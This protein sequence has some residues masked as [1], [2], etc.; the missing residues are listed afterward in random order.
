MSHPLPS[1]C[2]PRGSFAQA[3]PAPH[4]QGRPQLLRRRCGRARRQQQAGHVAGGDRTVDRGVHQAEAEE[5]H[6]RHVG[7]FEK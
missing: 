3:A 6:R 4:D 5:S 2:R 1:H 7:R